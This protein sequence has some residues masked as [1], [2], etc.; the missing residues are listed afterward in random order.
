MTVLLKSGIEIPC[1]VIERWDAASFRL[2]VMDGNHLTNLANVAEGLP[3]RYPS[4]INI[5]DIAA[6]VDG[7]INNRYPVQFML[8]KGMLNRRGMGMEPQ[9]KA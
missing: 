7:Y 9:I 6:I 4:S 8:N 5:E 1:A 2:L 3:V